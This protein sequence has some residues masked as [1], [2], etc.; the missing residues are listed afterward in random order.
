MN[1]KII[2]ITSIVMAG[3]AIMPLMAAAAGTPIISSVSPNTAVLQQD[4]TV[5]TVMGS[6]FVPGAV[7]N[8]NG[9]PLASTYVSLTEV[10]ATVPAADMVVASTSFIT[11]TN[12]GAA[13]SNSLTFTV[14]TVPALPNTGFGPVEPPAAQT[15]ESLLVAIMASFAVLTTIGAFKAWSKS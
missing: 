9:T 8:F 3:M 7:I 6:G 1:T 12:P 15:L 11:A 5:I 4:N 10:L 13:A 2:S 14:S